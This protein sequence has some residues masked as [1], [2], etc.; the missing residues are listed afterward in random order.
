[1]DEQIVVN[2]EQ[3]LMAIYD[4]DDTVW[5]RSEGMFEPDHNYYLY[6]QDG[7]DYLLVYVS[8]YDVDN[9]GGCLYHYTLCDYTRNGEINVVQQEE[10]RFGIYNGVGEAG[11]EFD[12][13]K[14]YE[15]CIRDRKGY[16]NYDRS[17]TIKRNKRFASCLAS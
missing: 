5:Y 6:E 13:Q 15:M 14:V 16:C 11:D 4:A 1:M 12:A 9:K 2:P 3:H 8:A 7:K 17:C 10:I